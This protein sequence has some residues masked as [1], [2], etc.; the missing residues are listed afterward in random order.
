[1]T[2]VGICQCF[3]RVCRCN[4]SVL[5]IWFKR[6]AID[7]GMYH[8]TYRSFQPV[9]AV[10]YL[11]AQRSQYM[12]PWEFYRRTWMSPPVLGCRGAAM[13]EAG[14]CSSWQ[15]LQGGR[16]HSLRLSWVVNMTSG[17]QI[18][19]GPGGEH[20]EMAS[21]RKTLCRHSP[22]PTN[23]GSDESLVVDSLIDTGN[24]LLFLLNPTTKQ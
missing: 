19:A 14:M 23:E 6:A 5:P 7:A 12:H 8:W 3:Y 13:V 15:G 10:S 2:L 16:V 21:A 17:S 4:L 22:Y 24:F 1:M 18:R 9:P 20:I 11:V